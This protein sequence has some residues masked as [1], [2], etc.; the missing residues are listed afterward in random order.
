MAKVTITMVVEIDEK[1]WARTYGMNE[2]D[3]TQD[4]KGMYGELAARRV[5]E[6]PLCKRIVTINGAMQPTIGAGR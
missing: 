5:E 2:W 1:E 3:A 6:H 4:A